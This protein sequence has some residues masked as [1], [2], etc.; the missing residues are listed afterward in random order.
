ME[1]EP[2]LI[3]DV[4]DAFE[5]YKH[6]RTVSREAKGLLDNAE[7]LLKQRLEEYDRAVK[8]EESRLANLKSKMKD[9]L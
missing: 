6:A 5:Q 3:V 4:M 1:K 2:T 9:Y 7:K 8:Q